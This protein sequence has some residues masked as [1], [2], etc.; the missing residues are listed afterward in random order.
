MS[1]TKYNQMVYKL[2]KAIQTEGVYLAINSMQFKRYKG[3]GF[4][5]VYSVCDLD[6]PRSKQE[7]FRSAQVVDV[8]KFLADYYKNLKEVNISE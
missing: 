7:L 3:E 6:L 4:I 1:L 5:K 8:V 2:Q